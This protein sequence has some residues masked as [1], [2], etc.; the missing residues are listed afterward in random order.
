MTLLRTCAAATCLI[1][2]SA[3]ELSQEAAT[4]S[5]FRTPSASGVISGGVDNDGQRSS[6]TVSDGAGGGFAVVSGTND[7]GLA[8]YAGIIPGTTVGDV[9]ATGG[10][11]FDAQF[12][13]AQITGVNLT[14]TGRGSGFITGRPSIV[15]GDITLVAD[16]DG[17]TLTGTSDGGTL[18][19]DGDIGTGTSLTGSVTY[20]GVNGALRGNVG[21]DRTIGVFH[22]NDEDTI[23]AGG[24]TGTPAE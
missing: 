19:V 22:G 6:R 17:G 1:A 5:G 11:T 15:S 24:F 13:T 10:A 23:F 20:L 9:Q 4:N 3:C 18:A 2:L 16:F 8:A 21:T 14:E 12:T 7:D